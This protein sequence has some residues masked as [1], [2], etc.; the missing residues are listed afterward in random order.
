MEWD[1][2]RPPSHQDEGSLTDKKAISE[3]LKEASK[4]RLLNALKQAQER[5]GD[6]PLDLEASA[7]FLEMDCFKKYEKVG[8]TFYNSQVAAT[9]RWLSSSSHEQIL[10]R[11]NA[12]STTLV[13]TN[14]KSV[15]PPPDP[16][17]LDHVPGEASTG[18]NQD[19]IKLKHSNESVEMK[20]P[21][22]KIELPQ[23]PSFSE[24]INQKRKEGQMGS[25]GVS[26]QYPSRGVQKRILDSQKNGA[27]NASKRIR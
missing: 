11:L 3:T 17:I 13:S 22:E 27:N 24:F 19:N 25:S 14:C 5:L 4:K 21:G 23:I 10:D 7:I 26:S 9:V 1:S 8:K 2:R 15:T 20:A 18:E 12:N 6:L 16:I